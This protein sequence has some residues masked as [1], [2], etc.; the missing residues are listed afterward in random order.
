MMR[1]ASRA[2]ARAASELGVVQPVVLGVT[3]LTSLDRQALEEEIGLALDGDLNAFITEKAKQAR[4]AGLGGVVASPNEAADIR[5]ACGGDFQ[6]IT[7]G[8]RPKWAST[9]EQKRIATPAEAIAVGADRIVVGRP[10]TRA[11][12]PTEAAERIIA[13]IEQGT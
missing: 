4:A 3:I 1:A 6:I 9:D 5:E 13:E 8:V 7:P 11:E 12:H 2:A 10:V